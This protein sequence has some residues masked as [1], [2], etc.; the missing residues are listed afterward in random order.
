MSEAAR[1]HR[2][3]VVVECHNDLL[4]LVARERALGRPDAFRNYW[5]PN[6]REG[7]VDVQMVPLYVEAEYL[8]E[9]ALRR[10]LKLIRILH[11]E[12]EK[13]SEEVAL[14]GD[15]RE[16]DEATASGKIALVLAF[17]GSAAIGAEVDLFEIFFRLGLRMASYSWFG[18]TALA[19]GSG[20]EQTGGRLTR[21]GIAA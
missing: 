3:A 12:V 20:E 14:C 19:D 7:G 6:L 11:D 8:P 21:A 16:I 9:G 1:I 13:N 5:L 18:R 17:E 2:D 10:T 4:L 15:G